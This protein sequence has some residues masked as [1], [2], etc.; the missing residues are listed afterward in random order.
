MPS[1]SSKSSSSGRVIEQGYQ[2][3]AYQL[4]PGAASKSHAAIA[5]PLIQP[6]QNPQTPITS[7]K[8]PA[9]SCLG[10]FRTPALYTSLDPRRR[11]PKTFTKA[12]LTRRRSPLDELRD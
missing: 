2:R 3:P 1:A 10:G 8:C 5:A 9:G 6:Q 12:D 7:H 11:H 4:P